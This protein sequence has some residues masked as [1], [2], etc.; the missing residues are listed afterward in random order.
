MRATRKRCPALGDVPVV[1]NLFKS[2]TRSRKKTNLMVFLR[3]VV[4]RDAAG[5]DELSLDRYELMRG[6]QGG[7]GQPTSS[8]WCRSTR[9][10][11]CPN[12]NGR[13][14]GRRAPATAVPSP[15]APATAVP[16]PVPRPLGQ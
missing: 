13:A 8:L 3:P 2:E 9:P 12:C 16:G 1:G 14:A 11:S 4:V 6:K 10:R 5:S 7:G 15:V